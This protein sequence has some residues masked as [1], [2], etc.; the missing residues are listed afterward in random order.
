MIIVTSSIGLSDQGMSLRARVTEG[1]KWWGMT[2]MMLLH[3]DIP[4][5]SLLAG[6]GVASSLSQYVEAATRSRRHILTALG[7]HP[8]F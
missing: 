4:G 8:L 2:P 6:E 7:Q 1:A 3:E 5:P